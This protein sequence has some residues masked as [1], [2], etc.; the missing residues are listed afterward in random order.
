MKYKKRIIL[1]VFPVLVQVL[2]YAVDDSEKFNYSL[3]KWR[4]TGINHYYIKVDYRA[5]SPLAGLWEIEVKKGRVVSS[6]FNG[7]NAEQYLK[8][9]GHL[10]MESLYKR[11]EDSIGGKVGIDNDPMI[12]EIGYD[13]VTGF[14]K[15]IS[16]V[17]NPEY[18]ARVKRDAGYSISVLEFHP[19]K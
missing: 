5:F 1:T 16:R 15:S 10:T 11:A 6:E 13:S 19:L 9:A 14:I 12:T 3:K 7:K 8:T 18:K 17:N 4:E 2:V